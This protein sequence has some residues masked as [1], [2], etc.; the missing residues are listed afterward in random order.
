[1]SSFKQILTVD[2]LNPNFDENQQ[3]PIFIFFT[4]SSDFH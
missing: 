2:P 4:I 3:T 1:M